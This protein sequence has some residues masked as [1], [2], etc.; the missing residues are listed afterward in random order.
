[1][2]VSEIFSG[3]YYDEF[4]EYSKEYDKNDANYYNPFKF[5]EYDRKRIEL[6]RKYAFPLLNP[7]GTAK[8]LEFAAFPNA[9]ILS[10]GS[11]RC[12][13]EWL[14]KNQ[15]QSIE[16]IA[17]DPFPPSTDKNDYFENA[18]EYMDVLP[19]SAEEAI[20]KISSETDINNIILMMSWPCLYNDWSDKA[21]NHFRDLGG[22][23]IIFMGENNGCCGSSELFRIFENEWDAKWIH[24]GMSN[25]KRIHDNLVFYTR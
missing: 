3:P 17:S 14:L 11:G 16:I 18:S 19:L 2:E 4:I 1:M 12:Y 24:G 10:V 20:T 22:N 15:K 5:L 25:W 9:V 21:V 8:I 13:N 6:T 7:I 23:K